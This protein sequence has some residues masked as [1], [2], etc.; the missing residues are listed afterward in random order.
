MG[1]GCFCEGGQS[2][3]SLSESRSKDEIKRMTILREKRKESTRNR[4]YFGVTVK[5]KVSTH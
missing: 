5:D 2:E 3:L 4:R 1:M